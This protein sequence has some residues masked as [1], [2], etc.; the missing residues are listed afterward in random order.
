MKTYKSLFFL[1]ISTFFLMTFSGQSMARVFVCTQLDC[2]NNHWAPITVAQQQLQ[3]PGGVY[4]VTI[5]QALAGS[6][7]AIIRNNT[8]NGTASDLYLKYDLW[9]RGGAIPPGA[10]TD[11][12][13]TAYV[14]NAANNQIHEA[15][16]H[17]FPVVRAG[18]YITTC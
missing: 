13:L 1:I 3:P 10:G 12:H 5:A 17:I 14:Y 6:E 16:C 2:D 8:G 9:H 15:S 7:A 11:M 4:H 18:R